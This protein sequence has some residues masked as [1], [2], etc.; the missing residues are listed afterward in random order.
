M[1]V[2]AGVWSPGACAAEAPAA[3]PAPSAETSRKLDAGLP[4]VQRLLQ[5]MDADANGKVSKDEFMRFMEAEF[6]KADVNHDN[7]LD[8]KELSRLVQSLTHPV[9]GPAR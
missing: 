5:L 9:R 8:P 4:A 7:E 3:T 6:D 2:A 1:L